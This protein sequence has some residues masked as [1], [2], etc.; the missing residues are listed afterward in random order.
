MKHRHRKLIAEA[1]SVAPASLPENADI[2]QTEGWD[3]IG[4]IRLILAIEEK[5]GRQLTPEEVTEV[6]DFDAVVKLLA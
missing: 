4:H 5:L 3:S 2:G 6:T 1:L